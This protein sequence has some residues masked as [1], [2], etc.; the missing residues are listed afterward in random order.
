MVSSMVSSQS[1]ISIVY[2]WRNQ[3]ILLI[4]SK[5]LLLTLSHSIC[6]TH[7]LPLLTIFICIYMYVNQSCDIAM[8]APNHVVG[9]QFHARI[10]FCPE[11]ALHV[12]KFRQWDSHVLSMEVSWRISG[13]DMHC[14]I[15]H[16]WLRAMELRHFHWPYWLPSPLTTSMVWSSRSASLG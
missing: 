11:M 3:K 16:T 10:F 9:R 8:H 7:W 2:I 5:I 6:F 13:H 14:P 15:D 4:D 12:I 1:E